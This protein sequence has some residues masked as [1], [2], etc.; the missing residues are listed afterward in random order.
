MLLISYVIYGAAMIGYLLPVGGVLSPTLFWALL[1][2]LAMI[3]LIGSPDLLGA[4]PGD[5]AAFFRDQGI[6]HL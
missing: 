5:V 6:T 1:G 2:V 3:A 4:G